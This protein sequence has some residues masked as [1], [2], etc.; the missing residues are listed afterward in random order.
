MD[1]KETEQVQQTETL[2]QM[3][4][5]F[6]KERE[7][8]FKRNK[9]NVYFRLSGN[10]KY[11]NAHQCWDFTQY[12]LKNGFRGYKPSDIESIYFDTHSITIR[13]HSTAET[14]IKRFENSKELLNFVVG[15]NA[16][17]SEVA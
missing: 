11:Y 9:E 15:W 1:N 16:C 14:D 2:E 6:A 3:S 7:L 5:R 8:E 13:L 4:K 10:N 12:I 17:L